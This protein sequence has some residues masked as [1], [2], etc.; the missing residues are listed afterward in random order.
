MV[1]APQRLGHASPRQDRVELVVLEAGG[2][3]VRAVGHVVHEAAGDL[4]VEDRGIRRSPFRTLEALHRRARGAA[5]AREPAVGEQA[6]PAAP[7]PYADRNRGDGENEKGQKPRAPRERRHGLA[8][9]P[10]PRLDERD[11]AE[12]LLHLAARDPG[13]RHRG[14]T[15]DGHGGEI[16]P[17]LA[18]RARLRIEVAERGGGQI[19]APR[20]ERHDDPLPGLARA[21]VVRPRRGVLDDLRIVELRVRDRGQAGRL[22]RL[23]GSEPLHRDPQRDRVPD[24]RL[25]PVGRR[26]DPVRSDGPVEVGRLARLGERPRG[27]RQRGRL[28]LKVHQRLEPEEHPE[29][30]TRGTLDLDESRRLRDR[31]GAGC[32]RHDHLA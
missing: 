1:A 25:L 19:E 10:G 11:V 29:A 24:L 3:S 20:A 4:L 13:V 12:V 23:E 30:V 27:D 14:T 5:S 31:D 26:A 2:R 17:R 6:L 9:G 8:E 21:Q 15:H 7:G 28:A 32:R 22:G 16:G 18:I